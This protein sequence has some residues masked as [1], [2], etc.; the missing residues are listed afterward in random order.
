M[1]MLGNPETSTPAKVPN[2]SLQCCFKD[3]PRLPVI[4][5][6]SSAPVPASNPTAKMIISNSY[7]APDSFLVQL[8]LVSTD[9]DQLDVGPVEGLIV[10]MPARRALRTKRI[11]GTQDLCLLRVL[12]DRADFLANEL[13]ALLVGLRVHKHI[14]EGFHLEVE[15]ATFPAMVE[16]LSHLFGICLLDGPPG[17]F[18]CM[19]GE[20]PRCSFP[21]GIVAPLDVDD[22]V[23][24]DGVVAPWKHIV[25]GALKHR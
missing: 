19:A 14:I 4:S 22:L 9:V 8:N 21:R 6:W 13:R 10:V 23:F 12:H 1:N 18:A 20:I 7:S 25:R 3:M 2:L 16:D 24:V 17:C 15:A 11:L 5:I